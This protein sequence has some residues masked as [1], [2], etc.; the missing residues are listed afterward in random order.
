MYTTP[1]VPDEW[2]TPVTEGPEP[3]IQMRPIG[4]VTTA[5]TDASR[6]PI[7]AQR[8]RDSRGRVRVDAPYRSGLEDLSGFDYVFL[9]TYLDHPIR[10]YADPGEWRVVPFLLGSTRRAV[11]TFATR[12]P[13]RP[14]PIGL[15]LVRVIDVT[16]GGFDFSGVDLLDGTPVL[17]IKP[18]VPAF[19]TPQPPRFHVRTG[20]YDEAVLGQEG[21]SP[22]ELGPPPG[23]PHDA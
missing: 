18:W 22:A 4:R 11:G 19:D 2:T 3:E 1:D 15:S 9:I 7:Q 23:K 21:A 17:D 5:F 20:W 10:P 12:H 16:A 13:V 8:D 6:T 14:N